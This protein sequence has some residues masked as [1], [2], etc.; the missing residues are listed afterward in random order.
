MMDANLK[1]KWIEALRS[2]EYEQGEG[3][4]E[5]KRRYCCLGVLIKVQGKDPAEIFPESHPLKTSSVPIKFSGGLSREAMG[6]LAN[7][8]DGVNG[9]RHHS[10]SEIADYI[11]QNL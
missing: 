7:R 2:G 11:E 9:R 5:N 6:D 1:A 8:N 4:L 3:F 10:F